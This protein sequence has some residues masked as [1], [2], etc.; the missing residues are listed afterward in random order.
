MSR[1]APRFF[2]AFRAVARAQGWILGIGACLV[3][4]GL[5]LTARTDLHRGGVDP[6]QC[7]GRDLG[8][9]QEVIALLF[10]SYW[11]LSAFLI[12]KTGAWYDL[13]PP[14]ILLAL[15]ASTGVVLV[16]WFGVF[17]TLPAVN[18]WLDFGPKTPTVVRVNDVSSR[19]AYVNR[20]DHPNE[21]IVIATWPRRRLGTGELASPLATLWVGR[22]ALGVPWISR[23]DRR[24]LELG[25]APLFRFPSF[26]A[27]QGQPLMLI[28]LR[29]AESP[30]PEQR[31][32]RARLLAALREVAGN[33]A[34]TLPAVEAFYDQEVERARG[35]L[36]DDLL[37]IL[38]ARRA[39]ATPSELLGR[40]RLTAEAS[41]AQVGLSSAEQTGDLT[42][43]LDQLTAPS[44][45]QRE[46]SAAEA[47]QRLDDLFADRERERAVRRW[48]DGVVSRAPATTIA[49]VWEGDRRRHP[50]EVTCAHCRTLS[51]DD[52]DADLL[53][54]LAGDQKPF[55][56]AG[57]VFRVDGSGVRTAMAELMDS[58]AQP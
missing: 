30:T 45:N 42:G 11:L 44:R 54:L 5:S 13:S 15:I 53:A 37:R 46:R 31:I 49:I 50:F 25:D 56:G 10:G 32:R 14:R 48:V 55:E 18:A 38:V 57:R 21:S 26:T 43:L 35:A 17:S 7:F 8:G 47:A 34:V 24:P 6:Y 16:G 3:L 12:L 58:K 4:L 20:L 40:L 29:E 28:A 22:G 39:A 9:I 52:L 41:L 2:P 51:V 36:G 19:R 27:G 23:I 1:P 33:G